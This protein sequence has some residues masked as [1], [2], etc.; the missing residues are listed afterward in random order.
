MRVT[1]DGR[2]WAELRQGL[3][4]EICERGYGVVLATRGRDDYGWAYTVGMVDEYLHPELVI[5]GV[6]LGVA[7]TVL[8]ELADLVARGLRYDT[9]D[10]ALL[11]S[12]VEFVDVHDVHLHRGLMDGWFEYYRAAGRREMPFNVLQILLKFETTRTRLDTDRHVA[13]DGITPAARRGHACRK[14]R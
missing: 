5:A 10:A 14:A 2:T 8:D 4:Q 3:E 7:V 13:F 9:D 12:R 6:R 11:A 1:R